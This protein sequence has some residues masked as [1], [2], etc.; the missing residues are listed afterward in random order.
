MV[1]GFKDS[2]GQVIKGVPFYYS[3]ILESST[4]R[5]LAAQ[6]I[7]LKYS[8][9]GEA[10]SPNPRTARFSRRRSS[11]SE[12]GMGAAASSYSISKATYVLPVIFTFMVALDCLLFFSLMFP[13]AAVPLV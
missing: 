12:E 13:G 5:T 11:L 3:R 7:K 4:P 6:K 10:L 8:L 9:K 1:S 2:R